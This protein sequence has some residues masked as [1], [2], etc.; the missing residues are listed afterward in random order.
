MNITNQTF[1]QR[2]Y[3][4]NSL[5]H[6]SGKTGTTVRQTITEMGTMLEVKLDEP[7]NGNESCLFFKSELEA[8]EPTIEDYTKEVM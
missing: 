7:V 6:Y 2:V 3:V 5:S 1:P 4:S 8:L